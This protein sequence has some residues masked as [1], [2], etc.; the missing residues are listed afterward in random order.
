MTDQRRRE[1]LRHHV[2]QARHKS[3]IMPLEYNQLDWIEGPT[4][5]P[6]VP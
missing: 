4:A 6:A 2:N 3:D 1:F 5:S